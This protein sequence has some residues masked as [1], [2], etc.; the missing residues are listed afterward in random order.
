MAMAGKVQSPEKELRFTRAGQATLFWLLS[1]VC[2]AVTVTL[3]AT[4]LYR[5]V[6]PEL[7]HPAWA[8]PPLVLAGVAAWLAVRLTRHAYLI[9]SPWGIEIFPFFRPMTGMQLV[10]WQE[11]DAAE[12]NPALTRLTLHRDAEKTSG[13]HLS[14]RP[15]RKDR[16]EL[17]AKAVIGRA[18][19]GRS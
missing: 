6:N 19:S 2:A 10:V 11:V 1:A 17:L 13:I 14:L 16:R 5:E 3:A 15:I 4:S 9:L 8:L 18:Q 7:P 12:V